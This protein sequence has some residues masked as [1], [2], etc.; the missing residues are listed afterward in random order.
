MSSFRQERLELKENHGWTSEPDCQVFLA[1]R[2]AVR[3]DFPKGWVIEPGDG[4]TIKIQNRES[5]GADCCLKMNLF[6]LREDLDWS[7]ISVSRVLDEVLKKRNP[8][9]ILETAPTQRTNRD[10]LEMAWSGT[11]YRDRD[12]TREYWF[13]ALVGR[14]WN[15]QPI[16]TYSYLE[17]PTPT[18]RGMWDILLKTLILG[19]TSKTPLSE[20]ADPWAKTLSEVRCYPTAILRSKCPIRNRHPRRRVP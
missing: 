4:G 18:I 15:I 7:G 10:G 19:T 12:R 13:R 1:D 16:F 5:H 8:G 2:G 17:P 9:E 6:Y 20:S 14:K 3:F 11:R